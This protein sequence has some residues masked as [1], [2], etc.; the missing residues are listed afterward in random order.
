VKKAEDVSVAPTGK[1]IGLLK[2]AQDNLSPLAFDLA[3]VYEQC[4]GGELIDTDETVQAA[5]SIVAAV[6]T[7]HE[8]LSRLHNVLD[9]PWEGE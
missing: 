5:H 4:V 7:L 9:M 2:D 6:D 3:Y 1:A 8:A